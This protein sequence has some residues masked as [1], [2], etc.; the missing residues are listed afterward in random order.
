MIK[1]SHDRGVQV[2]ELNRPDK[3][4]AFTGAMYDH[5]LSTIVPAIPHVVLS[6]NRH[7][8]TRLQRSMSCMRLSV[9][10]WFKKL[11]PNLLGGFGVTIRSVF[12]QHFC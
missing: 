7:M 5:C 2:I 10:P 12:A 3:K 1:R 9:I 11:C 6:K 4:N 8:T